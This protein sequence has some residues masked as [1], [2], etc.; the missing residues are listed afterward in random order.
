MS[1]QTNPASDAAEI[2]LI[3]EDSPT[4]A[5]RLRYF[6]EQ[7]GYRVTAANNG[8]QAMV[9]LG[10]H[11]PALIISDIVMPEMTGYELCRRIKAD[12][13]TRD[14]PV[15]LL[16]ALSNAEDVLEGLAC[17]ADSFI[18]KPYSENYLLAHIEKLLANRLPRRS[19]SERTGVEIRL[20][21]KSH[22]VTVNPQQMLT[23]LVS[24][25]EAAVH[26]NAELIEAQDELSS[27]NERRAQTS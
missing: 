26:K 9:F 13:R 23:L 11:T 19:E 4:Q 22:A 8:Q 15:I 7:P 1:N 10:E 21:G 25:Y 16:T 14:I 3:V 18:T 17:G 5:E 27:L 20:A 12:A 2:L 6:L 24:T